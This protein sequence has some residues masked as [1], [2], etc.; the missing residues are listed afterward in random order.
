[1]GTA[2]DGCPT[3]ATAGSDRLARRVVELGL[4]GAFE[5]FA[6]ARRLEAAGRHIVHLEAGEPDFPTP[7][8]IVE[9]GVRALR[10]GMTHYTTS[11][12]TAELRAAIARS[13]ADRGVLAE[14]ANVIVTPGSKLAVFHVLT[15]LLEAGDE[16]LLPDPAYPAYAAVTTFV[17]A[18]A[19]SYRV[20]PETG[21]DVDALAERITPRTRVLVINSPHNPTGHALAPSALA[22]L[23]ELAERHDLI[24][25]SDE[26]YRMLSFG[27]TPIS[28]ASLPGM[29]E[30]TAIID[31]FSKAYAMTGWRLGY[32]VMPVW[33]AD[34]V[35]KLVNN[36]VACTAPFV[37]VA[38]I[39]AIEGPQDAVAAM[40]DEFRARRDFIVDAVNAIPGMR[41]ATPGGAFYVFPDVRSVLASRGSSVDAL[42][43]D[44]LET[45][46]VACVAGTA[47]GEHGRGALRLAYTQSRADLATA[48]TRVRAALAPG[49]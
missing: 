39:A 10:D 8:H 30:R 45:H 1:M 7:P 42:A 9:A 4:E 23:A 31:G 49:A 13:M 33:L 14:P 38:G 44:L 16:V 48:M 29:A 27:E 26:I 24:V 28:I 12:G 37:Q 32:G 21:V 15:A 47:F 20:D 36:S 2:L 18:R 6:A 40:R 43:R 35:G 19:V 3:T 41:C 46:G 25:I 22:R 5:V 11:N 34:Q 17:G